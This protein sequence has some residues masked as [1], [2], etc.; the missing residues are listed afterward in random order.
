MKGF[1]IVGG[2]VPGTDHTQP[3]KPAWKNNQDALQFVN[4]EGLLVAVVC[5]GCGSTPHSELGAR[6]GAQ[7]CA[8][9]LQV[10]ARYANQAVGSSLISREPRLF[11]FDV[12][13]SI[14]ANLEQTA[15]SLSVDQAEFER[16]IYEHFLFT[17]VGV[18]MT[19]ETVLIFS[20]GDGAYAVNGDA[21]IIPPC[22]GNMPPYI[23]YQLLPGT[24]D[25]IHLDFKMHAHLP[26]AEVASLLI[27]TD[28]TADII[29]RANELM[30]V[31]GTPLGPLSQFWEEERYIENPDAIRRRLAM[32]NREWVDYEVDQ[33]R[34]L[35]RYPQIKSGL[36][37]D[38]TTLVVVRRE[39]REED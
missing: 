28:G 19:E 30:P 1:R 15:R 29:A 10:M 6:F 12:Q 4:G 3:G 27:G 37:R 21:H 23:A 14:L 39:S 20:I 38:D 17:I 33:D 31:I 32:A 22:E 18:V 35:V 2:S 25:P 13:R 11:L 16:T 8:K 34:R 5:D 9:T 24:M 26:T 36:L 7:L